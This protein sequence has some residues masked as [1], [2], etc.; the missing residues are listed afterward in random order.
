[1]SLFPQA[2]L[3]HKAHFTIWFHS[4][5]PFFFLIFQTLRAAKQ[6]FVAPFK[7][8]TMKFSSVLDCV[9]LRTQCPIAS[10]K[11]SE[12]RWIRRN[13]VLARAT[14]DVMPPSAINSVSLLMLCCAPHPSRDAGEMSAPS[15][16]QRSKTVH[17]S[18]SKI[19][20]ISIRERWIKIILVWSVSNIC[21]ALRTPL[22]DYLLRN[23]HQNYQ[24]DRSFGVFFSSLNPKTKASS[25][26]L[27]NQS[28][29]VT[30]VWWCFASAQGGI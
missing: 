11:S 27:T 2:S 16:A 7:Q 6:R 3:A 13:K 29:A 10:L 14:G 20:T 15:P 8:T 5:C 24:T 4:L 18:L 28:M 19:E 17:Y 30:S 22:F 9:S 1:M 26:P 23:S 21:S 12:P 25:P